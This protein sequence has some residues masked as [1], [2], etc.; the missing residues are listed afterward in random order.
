MT[1]RFDLIVSMAAL[2]LLP[3]FAFAQAKLTV[4]AAPATQPFVP[5]VS[6]QHIEGGYAIV[7]SKSTGADA[8]WSKVVDTLK[9]K[10]GDQA[11]VITW[12]KIGG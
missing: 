12:E 10:Y 3:T 5:V 1:R 9:E 11:K 6:L 8:D 4:E 7:I 2:A